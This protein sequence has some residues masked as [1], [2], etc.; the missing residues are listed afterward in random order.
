MTN[1]TPTLVVW[2]GATLV[3][4]LIDNETPKNVVITK[5]HDTGHGLLVSGDPVENIVR[6]IMG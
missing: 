3:A 6:G 4:K 2:R 1:S 5:R